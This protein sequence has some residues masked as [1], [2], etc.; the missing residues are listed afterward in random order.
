MDLFRWRRIL[1]RA[2][3]PALAC[4]L[5][6]GWGVYAV[7]SDERPVYKT[8]ALLSTGVMTGSDKAAYVRDLVINELEGI[9][10]LARSFET[11]E[12]LATRLLADYLSLRGPDP[13]VISERAYADLAEH[14]AELEEDFGAGV[15]RRHRRRGERDRIYASLVAERD[16][17][18]R[19]G[20]ANAEHPLIDILYGDNELV[21]VENFHAALKVG[22]K[23]MSDILEISYE[24]VDAAWC[25][26]TLDV[27]IDIFL[28]AHTTTK[29][30]RSTG[31][32][33]YFRQATAD[34]RAALEAAERRHRAFSAEHRIINYYE[35]T[36]AIATQRKELDQS[37]TDQ[38]M[39]RA[40]A[41]EA[42][43]SLE[44]RLEGR[45]NLR[46][47]HDLVDVRRR[48]ITDLSRE[49]ARLQ[50]MTP[51]SLRRAGNRAEIASVSGRLSRARDA[52]KQEVAEL[53]NV[54]S[55][56]EGVQLSRLL[57]E[58]I[59][60]IL[61]QDES[62][63]RLSV[64][65][66]TQRDFDEMFKE[67]AYRGATL[68]KIEREVSIAEEEYLENLSSLNDALQREHAA[69]AS[70]DLRLVDEA[71]LPT[72]PQKSK[73]LM[74]VAAGGIVGGGFP[75]VLA[76]ALELLSGALTS[77]AEAERR[78]GLAV[79]GGVARWSW[80][81]QVLRKRHRQVLA[82]TTGDLLWQ[83]IRSKAQDT[84]PPGE[85]RL[86]ALTSLQPGAGKTY[87]ADT[88]AQ[89]LAARG[90]CVAVVT[91]SPEAIAPAERLLVRT[92]DT[93][94]VRAEGAAPWEVCGLRQNQWRALDVVLWELPA[95][96]TGRLPVEL[97]RR[98]SSVVLVHAPNHGWSDGHTASAGL[99]REA[100]GARAPLLLLNGVAADIL[101]NEWGANWRELR[102]WAAAPTTAETEAGPIAE[103]VAP[104]APDT[105]P[106]VMKPRAK[107]TEP[108][109]TEPTA[110]EPEGHADDRPA[111][112][113]V[114]SLATLQQPGWAAALL[115]SPSA[116]EVAAT[117][118]RRAPSASEA[119]AQPSAPPSPAPPPSSSWETDLLA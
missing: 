34:A 89:R 86:L 24:T 31:A 3:G 71:A 112:V 106:A 49:Q 116:V 63:G 74:M 59:A 102:R 16:S 22:R 117:R 40:A 95:V 10:N 78:S 20:E 105:R 51:D 118:Q 48:E 46:R 115:D 14:L 75:L 61:D 5:L 69:S 72:E 47:L 84:G 21:G 87:V 44:D 52:L 101:L 36:R 6:A 76:I 9:Q 1:L 90:F 65:E 56:P 58:W 97:A 98:A 62:R 92:A 17:L 4:A 32:L 81:R 28:A 26:R 35:Q 60:A 23:G 50:I 38:L 70:T 80:L 66:Q 114:P 99:L 13:A 100:A 107:V 29:D 108:R 73:R 88:L 8:S 19:F 109:A 77:F 93:L 37:H 55:G 11:R 25:K 119:R 53:Q 79:V 27:H 68:K 91:D 2:L 57:N 45:M 103:P 18:L 96:A 104:S 12:E 85:P 7:T 39:K 30:E 67:L 42:I 54:Y 43:A 64:I 111:D 83:G 110:E 41:D 94:G 113:P 82:D 33:A 15:F